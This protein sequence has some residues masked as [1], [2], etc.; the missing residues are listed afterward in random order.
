MSSIRRIAHAFEPK[1]ITKRT[2]LKAM[3][4]L[5][6]TFLNAMCDEMSSL[7]EHS[8]VKT[9]NERVVSGAIDIIFPSDMAKYA[10]Q[11]VAEALRTYDA[12]IKEEK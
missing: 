9:I 6:I 4:Q 12:S 3:Q 7:A 5:A 11:N 2:T 10:Q 8:G 1:T